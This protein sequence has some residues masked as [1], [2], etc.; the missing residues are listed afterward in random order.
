MFRFLGVD[1]GKRHRRTFS[2]ERLTDRADQMDF[3]VKF[4]TCGIIECR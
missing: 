3:K 2:L 4:M 1:H